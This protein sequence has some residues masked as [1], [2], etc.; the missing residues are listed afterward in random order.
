MPSR[1]TDQPRSS[2]DRG[3]PAVDNPKP[4]T[5]RHS[6]CGQQPQSIRVE[7]RRNQATVPRRIDD[8]SDPAIKLRGRL[9]FLP[10]L[11]YVGRIRDKQDPRVHDDVTE[12][13]SLK[14][15]L[16]LGIHC[17]AFVSAI[18]SLELVSSAR[19]TLSCMR[20]EGCSETGQE[21]RD[22]DQHPD[23]SPACHFRSRLHGAKSSAGDARSGLLGPLGPLAA[24]PALRSLDQRVRCQASPRLR[25]I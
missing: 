5:F 11:P 10:F 23:H 17:L 12:V 3:H 18:S 8:L 7:L 21:R 24:P 15:V 13:D 25:H 16:R 6:G 19:G 4:G 1:W 20:W 22:Q 2:R 9:A 14:C